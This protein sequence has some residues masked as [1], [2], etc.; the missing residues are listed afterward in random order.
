MDE[1]VKTAGEAHIE[2]LLQQLEPGS[3]RYLVLHTARRFKSSWVE[4]GEALFKVSSRH[5]YR[6]WGFESFEEY[7]QQEIRIRKPTAQKLTQA[8]RFLSREEPQLL[9]EET[10]LKPLPDYRSIDLLRQA[11]E[12]K[13]FSDADY[14]TLRSA[15]IEQERSHPTALKCFQ[16]LA[17]EEPGAEQRN[18]RRFKAALTSVRR[19]AG[20]LRELEEIPEH[21]HAALAELAAYLESALQPTTT[22]PIEE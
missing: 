2:T 7:C 14:A 8:Y 20:S 21:H 6:E 4:L 11:R 10:A 1:T 16:T 17:G 3:D 12:E 18:P 19:L 9:Q 15:V 22:E 13:Q 5:L